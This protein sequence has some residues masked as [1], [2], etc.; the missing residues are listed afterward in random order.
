MEYSIIQRP[1][2]ESREAD[3][4][5]AKRIG[6]LDK[7]ARKQ[8]PGAIVFSLIWFIGA[9]LIRVSHSFPVAKEDDLFIRLKTENS[10]YSV[11]FELK[12]AKEHNIVKVGCYE[13]DW[14]LSFLDT[15]CKWYHLADPQPDDHCPNL[16]I[17]N[18]LKDKMRERRQSCANELLP[19][20]EA[21]LANIPE[22]KRNI[23]T[24]FA[25][26]LSRSISDKPYPHP[27]LDIKAAL[28]S[29]LP[30]SSWN[31]LSPKMKSKSKADA[32]QELSESCT[33]VVKELSSLSTRLS[34]IQD[35]NV[36]VANWYRT[37][38]YCRIY[39]ESVQEKE[40][41][42][43]PLSELEQALRELKPL[44]FKKIK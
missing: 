8:L 24:T 31:P 28:K 35:G 2:A 22:D 21:A 30:K 14:L 20:L 27:F 19:R 4:M 40:K 17:D 43:E 12:W 36:T 6:L 9:S 16:G 37:W 34:I 5:I 10:V 1:K 44:K 26:I 11:E 23:A 29:Y 39:L 18:F 25:L 42:D 32:L 41:N 38:N 7:Q 15:S 33:L 13:L 3:R